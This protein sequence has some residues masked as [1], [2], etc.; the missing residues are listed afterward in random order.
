VLA[1][2]PPAVEDVCRTA[3][4]SPSPEARLVALRSL[5]LLA[6]ERSTQC[7]LDAT[8][9]GDPAVRASAAASLGALAV[10]GRVGA[11]ALYDV[12]TRLS[13]DSEPGVRAAVVASLVLFDERNARKR[14]ARLA[15][16]AD[17]AVREAATQGL[18]SL[19]SLRRIEDVQQLGR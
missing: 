9:H 14:L 16:D 1:L 6:T 12:A 3:V 8:F 15:E 5:G 17:A 2:G 18:G 7:Y 11:E 13:G 19:E 4:E 10:G